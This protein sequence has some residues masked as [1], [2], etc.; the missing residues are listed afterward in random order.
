M[1]APSGRPIVKSLFGIKVKKRHCRRELLQS[2]ERNVPGDVVFLYTLGPRS[3]D[4]KI[5]AESAGSTSPLYDVANDEACFTPSMVLYWVS[6]T[7]LA[8]FTP[9]F[10]HILLNI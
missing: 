7:N 5:A 1:I 2:K 9:L 8:P 6:L 3:T 4:Y 10:Y